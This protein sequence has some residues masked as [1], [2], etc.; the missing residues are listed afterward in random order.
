MALGP[1]DN[2]DELHNY[3]STALQLEHATIPPYLT[4]LYSLHPGTNSDAFHILRTVA[5][6]EM[7]HTTLVANIMN[8]V[9]MSPDLTQPGF[10]PEYPT[11]LPS[12]ETDFKV[13]RQNFCRES[14]ETF[15][16]IERPA[17]PPPDQPLAF[18]LTTGT[19][20][21]LIARHAH[22]NSLLGAYKPAGNNLSFGNLDD[23]TELHFYSIG[24][25]YKEI[26]RGL[27]ELDEK[28][29]KEGKQLFR[30]D[31]KNQVTP[32]YY[33]SGGGEL[34]TVTD[35]ATAQEAIRLISEQGEGDGGAIF[36]HEGEISHYYRFQ[37]LERG[38]Y[39][40]KGDQLGK[41]SGDALKIDWDAVYPI[42][43]D[44]K[45]A[46]YPAN[47]PVYAAA[48]DFNTYYSQ[49]L[50]RLTQ[51][52]TGQPQMLI[53]AVQDMFQIR[54]K[55]TQLMRNPI[56]GQPMVNASPTFEMPV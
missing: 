18:G 43:T 48:L 34:M 26:S 17:A 31:F 28:M 39:Y 42:K 46:D 7:L 1:L 9:G 22:T 36:D 51:A 45:L 3:L 52:F 6:E 8:A 21:H 29:Q 16:K 35:L 14:V 56:P 54:E 38:Q 15:L 13:S 19:G 12:G 2:L 33:Y 44:A 50:S 23:D 53:E 25:F 4:A 5:V 32:E 55:A 20:P 11:Y 30:G 24:E 47:T 49:F 40:L 27:A 37:Q 10:V 41:P